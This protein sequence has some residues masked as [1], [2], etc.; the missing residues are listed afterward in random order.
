MTFRNYIIDSDTI[1]ESGKGYIGV[2]YDSIGNVRDFISDNR[3][4]S[5]NNS[6]P[7]F[8]EYQGKLQLLSPTNDGRIKSFTDID[9][10]LFGSFTYYQD[11]ALEV[12]LGYNLSGD[13]YDLNNDGK[14]DIVLGNESGGIN[15][16]YG[17]GFVGIDDQLPSFKSSNR[18]GLSVFPNPTDGEFNIQ[19]TNFKEGNNYQIKIFDL[20]GKLILSKSINQ[21]ITRLDINQ[22][23]KGIYFI[24]LLTDGKVSRSEKLVIR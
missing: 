12:N 1:N 16:L 2:V 10:N 24:Q 18:S 19:L 6:Q 15:I 5:S 17:D 4:R 7:L 21:E 3:N 20:V 13:V 23:N 22:Q 14:I 8:Y 9:S 11:N